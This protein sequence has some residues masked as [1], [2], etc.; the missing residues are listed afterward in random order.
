[1]H[2]EKGYACRVL[3]GKPEGNR[4][5]EITGHRCEDK[6]KLILNRIRGHGLN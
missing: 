2:G 3:V 1:M 6:L 5:R 4:L